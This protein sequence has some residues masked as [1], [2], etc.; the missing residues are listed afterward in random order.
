MS[1]IRVTQDSNITRYGI[2]QTREHRESRVARVINV[3]ECNHL[4]CKLIPKQ[5]FKRCFICT[6]FKS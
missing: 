3:M 2:E 6:D 4:N 1:H 5:H